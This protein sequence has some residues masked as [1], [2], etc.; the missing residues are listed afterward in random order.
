[1]LHAHFLT[2]PLLLA[3][4]TVFALAQASDDA[5]TFRE[6]AE[7]LNDRCV[8]CHSGG[9][10]PLGLELDSLAGLQ[11]GSWNGPVAKP[12]NPEESELVRRI[13]GLSQPRMPFDGPPYLDDAEIALMEQWVA[14]GMPAGG[15]PPPAPQARPVPG[16]GEPVRFADVEPIFLQRCIKC[17]S[18]ASV[19]GAP[20]EGLRLSSRELILAGG[21]RVVVVPGNPGASEVV[22]RIRGQ[23][24]PRMPL[25]GP[26]FLDEE[27]IRLIVAWIEQGAPDNDGA[28]A[29]LPVG[30]RLRLE[31]TLTGRWRLDDTPLTVTPDSRI[32]D[33]PRIGERVEVRGV[34]GEDGSVVVTRLRRR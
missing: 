29:P 28:A 26:P 4:M 33:A 11:S 34:V 10:A 25:D 1:M 16:P 24:Q 32:D 3:A 31:G 9:G 23:S 13:K 19:L 14:A 7:I 17:H 12:G 18:D 6:V 2:L 27:Q 5:P 21:D 22:R 8:K 15:E 30:A 20:P